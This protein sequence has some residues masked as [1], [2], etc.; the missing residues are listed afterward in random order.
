MTRSETWAKATARRLPQGKVLVL[1]Y[2]DGVW[3][4]GEM[5]KDYVYEYTDL[6]NGKEAESAELLGALRSAYDAATESGR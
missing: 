2:Y 1:T 5:F 6:I 4:A 3:H